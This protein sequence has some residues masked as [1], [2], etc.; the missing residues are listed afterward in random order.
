MCELGARGAYAVKS[1]RSR[2]LEEERPDVECYVVA[3]RLRHL[4]SADLLTQ[5]PV[6]T[7]PFERYP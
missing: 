6:S 2:I 5:R 1:G 4:G 7:A 3:P